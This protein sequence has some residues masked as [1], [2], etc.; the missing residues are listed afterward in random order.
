MARCLLSRRQWRQLCPLLP[1]ERGQGRPYAQTHHITIEG[2]LWVARTGAPWRDLPQCFG[3]WNSVYKRFNRWVKGGIFEGLFNSLAQ[4]LELDVIM[5][6]GTFIKV[7]P[8]GTGAPTAEARPRNP[9]P[10]KR[11][12]SVRVGL[13]PR[14]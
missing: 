2:I 1:P 10:N 11:W 7:H 13:P 3:K 9:V 12:G 6:D 4:E 14:L 8:H 5:V